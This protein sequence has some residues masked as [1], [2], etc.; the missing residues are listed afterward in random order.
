MLTLIVT[1]PLKRPTATTSCKAVLTEDGRTVQRHVDVPLALL[2]AP[3]GAEI[4]ALIPA[5]ALSWH[6]LALPRGTLD[7]G[8][9]QEGNGVK[10]RAVLDGLLEDRLLDEPAQLHLAIAPQASTSEPVWVAACDRVWL[11]AWLAALEQAGRPVTRIVPET[12]PPTG[13]E[14]LRLHITGTPDKAQLLAS[15]PKGINVLPLSP[16]SLALVAGPDADAPAQIFAEPAVAALAEQQLKHPVQLQTEPERAVLAAQ[17]H[18]DLAQFDC[19]ASRRARSRKRWSSLS[20]S[21]LQSPRW[22]AARWALLALLLVNLAGLQSWAWHEQAALA[23]KR[24]AIREALTSTFPDVR[25]VVDAPLQ[26]ARALADLTRQ[27]GAASSADLETMLGRFQ[28]LAPAERAP[29]AIEFIA[30]ELQLKGLHTSTSA[31]SAIASQLQAQGYSARW[32]GASL[33][34]EPAQPERRP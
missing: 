34:I 6:Q 18:W 32:D 3:A 20:S 10:L 23:A 11:H 1:L 24:A 4:V 25:V 9:F 22:R 7:K 19:S 15:G 27:S 16:A 14:A 30:N 33:R 13:T 12:A 5:D 17:T 2:S 31:Q 26:M 29:E 21:L 28:A 8:F